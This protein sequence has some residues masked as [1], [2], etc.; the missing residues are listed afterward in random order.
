MPKTVV[1]INELNKSY[2]IGS[3]NFKKLKNLIFNNVEKNNLIKRNE[4]FLALKNINLNIK[5]NENIALI[6]ENGMGKS[7]LCKII[8]G[9]TEPDSG[10]IKID[11]KIIPML[12]LHY[13]IELECTGLENIYFLGSAF[14]ASKTMIEKKLDEIL[15][16]SETKK[17]LNTQ[18]KK[19]SSGM[20]TRLVFSTLVHLEG[21][22]IIADEILAVS[23]QRFKEKCIEKLKDLNNQGKSLICVS[24]E[25]NIISKICTKAYV[26]LEQGVISEKLDIEEAY[27]YYNEKTIINFKKN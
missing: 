3:Y 1:E 25:Q 19:Y 8:A 5:D 24:H 12:N 6:G 7:T 17:Y 20:F 14:G 16:F 15:E 26:F 22:I 27:D 2:F 23:D 4:N 10:S 11:G 13:G 9:I 18:L 21:D